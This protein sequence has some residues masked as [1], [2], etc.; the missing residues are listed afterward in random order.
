MN[1]RQLD[2]PTHDIIESGQ[3]GIEV[4]EEIV[5]TF[6]V[7]TKCIYITLVSMMN[8]NIQ[9][10]DRNQYAIGFVCPLFNRVFEPS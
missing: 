9:N 3:I 1:F 8:L 10:C 7:I 5:Y 2:T 6:L 4:D